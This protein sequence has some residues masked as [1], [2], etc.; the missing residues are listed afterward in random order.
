MNTGREKMTSKNGANSMFTEIVDCGMSR[1]V[2]NTSE[3]ALNCSNWK[4]QNQGLH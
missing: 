1:F 3:K 2:I 4:N